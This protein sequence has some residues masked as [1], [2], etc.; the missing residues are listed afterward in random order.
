MN[1]IVEQKSLEAQKAIN[2][3]LAEK[4]NKTA[5]EII[6]ISKIS[7]ILWVILF[8]AFAGTMLLLSFPL[9]IVKI[10]LSLFILFLIGYSI[11][12]ERKRIKRWRALKEKIKEIQSESDKI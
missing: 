11:R 7:I 1:K 4:I 9:W 6:S 5:D 8:F 3:D 2:K 12:F 10:I